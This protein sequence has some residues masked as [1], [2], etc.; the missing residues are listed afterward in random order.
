[1]NY[2]CFMGVV[3][4]DKKTGKTKVL[5]YVVTAD[6]GVIGN[7]L[8]VEGQAYGGISHTIGYALKEEYDDLKK[9]GSMAGAGI[10]YI[11]DIPD[12]IQLYFSENPREHGP[13]GSSGCSELFQSAGHMCVINAIHDAV[14][15][16]MYELPARPEKVKAAMEA[17]AEGRELK[18]DKYYFGADMFDVLEEITQ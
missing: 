6:V 3:E 13:H 4:V 1:M 16:R 14:G 12:D 2:G 11:E 8:A 9:G 7:Q 10:P 5:R 15:V 17:K 18:P